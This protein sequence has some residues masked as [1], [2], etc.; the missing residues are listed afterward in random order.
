VNPARRLRQYRR[1]VSDG[2]ATWWSTVPEGLV[3]SV[4]V[5]PGA[6]RSEVVDAS[7]E[8]LRVRI[9]APATEGKANAEVRRFIGELF[10][11]RAARVSL[12]RGERARDKVVLVEGV[13]APPDALVGSAR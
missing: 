10:G 12:R 7:G 9:A 4:R 6:R 5:T 1:L 2:S 8:Q 13:D 11:V 3:V